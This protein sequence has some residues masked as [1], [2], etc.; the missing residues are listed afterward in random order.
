MVVGEIPDA[1]DFIVVGAGPGGYA[2][3]LRAA[4]RGRQVTLV[5]RLGEQGVGGV[6]LNTGCIPSKALIEVANAVHAVSALQPAGLTAG[7]VRL[8]IERWQQWKRGVVDG[9]ADGVRRLLR[10]AG[11]QMLGGHVRLTRPDQAVIET[12]DDRAV[13][14]EFQDAVIATGSRAA[15][16][17]NLPRDGSLVLDSTDALELRAL[18]SDV[19]I[20]GGGYIGLEIGTA[21]AKL[22]SSVTIVEALDRVL[23]HLDEVVA[24][25]V[26]NRLRELGVNLLVNAVAGQFDGERL[27]VHHN[28]GTQHLKVEQV[29]VAAGRKPNTDDLGLE[30]AGLAP[31]EHGLLAVAPDRRLTPHIAAI[32]DIT[33]GPVLAHK[34]TAEAQVAVDALCGRATAF[35]PQAVPAVVFSDPEVAVAGLGLQEARDAGFDV[36]GASVHLAASGRARILNAREGLLQ[37][38]FER[39]S[40]AIVGVQA[41]GP[42]ASE[43]IAEGV[44]AIEMGAT[45]EDLAL[46][47]HPHPTMSEQISEAAH[48]A[49]RRSRAAT[50]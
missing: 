50:R 22:G 7:T 18:P 16:V 47:M 43:V 12:M 5:D 3:A 13:F 38:V 17:P 49:L 4:E 14:I 23:P 33:P 10:Q 37:I 44:L 40:G 26:A 48:R 15:D 8:D 31:D 21:L 6:C 25:R 36:D 39:A 28:G 2:A 11:V 24:R 35:D 19:A 30:G 45:V 41:V 20:I 46:T 34:A 9:L 29:V 1:V 42:H 27:E 32:G